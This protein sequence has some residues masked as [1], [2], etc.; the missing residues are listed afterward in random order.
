MKKYLIITILALLIS[1][2]SMGKLE[3]SMLTFAG[4]SESWSVIITEDLRTITHTDERGHTSRK[5][6]SRMKMYIKYVGKSVEEIDEVRYE[7]KIG[8]S[9]G[10]S[11]D[12]LNQYG[13]II[14][15]IGSNNARVYEDSIIKMTF[16]WN[17]LVEELEAIYDENKIH[18]SAILN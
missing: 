14:L 6:S 11:V 2:C 7:F 10:V 8:S 13:A 5:H 16:E 4:E 12:Q 1:G 9:Y 3:S 18:L 15:P 17:G